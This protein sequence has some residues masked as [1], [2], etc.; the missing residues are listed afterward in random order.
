M[1]ITAAITGLDARRMNA[2]TYEEKLRWLSDL[3]GMIRTRILDNYAPG[4]VPFAGY[5]LDTP[6]HTELLVSAP[7]DGLYLWWL[8]A[9][10]D[11]SNGEL[12]RYNNSIAQFDY[13]YGLFAD[14]YHRTHSP[15]M[16]RK[17]F[18]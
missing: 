2:C 5:T 12:V 16:P 3:D 11:H 17:G 1:N 14:Y 8:E 18:F 4:A 6:G 15:L 7:F 9:C 13:L 10:V